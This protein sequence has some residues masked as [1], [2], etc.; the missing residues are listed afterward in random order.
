MTDNSINNILVPLDLSENSLYA[1]E[2]AGFLASK[3][4]AT[5]TVLNVIEPSFSRNDDNRLLS[6]SDLVSLDV[7]AALTGSVLQ[8]R[9]QKPEFIQREG[10]VV[11]QV[12]KTAAELDCDLIVMG[13]HG[14]SGFRD[15][16]MGSNAYGVVKYASCAVLIIPANSNKAGFSKALFPIRAVKGALRSYE[17][18]RHFIAPKGMLQ[19]LGLSYL[20]IKRETRLLDQVIDDIRVQLNNDGMEV[21][22]SWGHGVSVPQDV[23]QYAQLNGSQLIVVNSSLDVTTK[24]DYI[25][26]HIQRILHQSSTPVLHLKKYSLS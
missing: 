9:E 16:Y 12:I 25:G 5:I 4:D 15:Q 14:A 6:N 18:A 20:K 23:L 3:L 7:L 19:V 11:E 13:K 2:A 26:P 24:P 22:S 10:S 8:N 17:T 1:L 21:D